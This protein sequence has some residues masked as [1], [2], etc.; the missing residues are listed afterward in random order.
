RILFFQPILRVI[1][2]NPKK[3]AA[4]AL[5]AGWL[6]NWLYTRQAERAEL[7]QHCRWAKAFGDAPVSG[8]WQQTGQ[9]R[10]Q[11]QQQQQ[12]RRVT[13]LFN[14]RAAQSAWFEKALSPMLHLA[15]FEVQL[16]EGDAEDENKGFMEV[17]DLNSTDAVLVAGG[18]GTLMQAV[19]GLLRRPDSRRIAARLPVA[20]AP[21]GRRSDSTS[22]VSTGVGGG[23][24][25]AEGLPE[26]CRRT[27]EALLQATSANFNN[28]ATTTKRIAAV[29]PMRVRVRLGGDSELPRDTY[30]LTALE[31]SSLRQRERATEASAIRRNLPTVA[32]RCLHWLAETAS[33]SAAAAVPVGCVIDWTPACPGCARCVAPAP[34]RSLSSRLLSVSQRPSPA[35]Q[36]QQLATASVNPDCGQWRQLEVPATLGIRLSPTPTGTAGGVLL[37]LA[38]QAASC[39]GPSAPDCLVATLPLP[40]LESI[41]STLTALRLNYWLA[42]SPVRLLRNN[43]AAASA[44]QPTPEELEKQKKKETPYFLDNELFDPVDV[45][46]S[47]SEVPLLLCA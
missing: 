30:C 15:G 23:A 40:Q 44:Q 11:S 32:Q 22:T 33:P 21:L 46:V 35:Q 16:V 39:G 14:P 18:D 37:Q 34:A 17:L 9:R 12:P 27:V 10:P 26:A 29:R 1:R 28:T 38:Y 8:Q 43:E 31:W 19:T 6:A 20:A 13:V 45:Q 47:L 42:A 7:R 2:E 3:C 24:S 4:G 25:P 5:A 41:S 36:Q